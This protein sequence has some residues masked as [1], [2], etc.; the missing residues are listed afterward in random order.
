MENTLTSLFTRAKNKKQRSE[1]MHDESTAWTG[2]A[3]ALGALIFL[4][5]GITNASYKW[6]KEEGKREYLEEIVR[7][8]HGFIV[9]EVEN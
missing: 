5:I 2:T 4:V 9:K 1:I 7:G 8:E 3:I 6:G